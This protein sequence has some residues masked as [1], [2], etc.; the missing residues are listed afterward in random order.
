LLKIISRFRRPERLTA[1]LPASNSGV[2]NSADFCAIFGICSEVQSP[3]KSP[4]YTGQR[5]PHPYQAGAQK[6]LSEEI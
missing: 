1:A 4:N 6:V 2:S 3:M 5:N